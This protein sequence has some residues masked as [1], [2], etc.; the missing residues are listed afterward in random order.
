MKLVVLGLSITSAWGN[1]HATTY[2]ALLAGLAAAGH[3]VTFLERDVPWYASH[4]DMPQPDYCVVAL[5]RDLDE[6]QRHAATV[7]AA[8]AVILGS[9]VQDGAAVARWML[10]IAGGTTAFYDIDTPVTVAALLRGECAYLTAE[11]VPAFDL[12]LSFTGG[13]MLERLTGELGAR[14]AAPLFCSVDEEL[15]RPSP[16]DPA[17]DLGYLGTYAPDRQAALERLLIEPARQRPERRFVVAGAQYP[18]GLAWPPNI[19]R[20]HHVPPEA[21][22]AFYGAQRFTLNVTRKDMVAA[23]HA[24]SVR[25]FE[26]AACGVPVISDRWPGLAELFRPGAEIVV[27]DGADDVLEALD[28]MD[29]PARRSMGAAAR[30]R[31][32]REHTGRARAGELVT[33]LDAVQRGQQPGPL[34]VQATGAKARAP[35]A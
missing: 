22:A 6:L 15:Y 11:L 3:E 7:A 23:G 5:Y 8:D 26:A 12:Y 1:G 13:P 19:A 20:H 21:H 18:E 34:S 16:G 25:L 31:V 28:G 4:R 30:A 24:P 32:L 2:R 10:G 29:E 17:L 14:A 9:F 27:A 35:V 33:L